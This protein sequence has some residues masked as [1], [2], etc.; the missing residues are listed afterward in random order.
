MS[1]QGFILLLGPG[2]MNVCKREGRF[3]ALR[4]AAPGGACLPKALGV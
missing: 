4:L 1:L 3:L 2:E